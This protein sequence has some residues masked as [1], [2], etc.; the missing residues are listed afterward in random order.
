MLSIA[1]FFVDN[2]LLFVGSFLNQE[3]I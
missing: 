1:Y 2:I 3:A